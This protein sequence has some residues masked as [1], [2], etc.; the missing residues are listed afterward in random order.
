MSFTPS[1][2]VKSVLDGRHARSGLAVVL[3]SGEY[4][5]RKRFRIWRR[6]E[7]PARYGATTSSSTVDPPAA[8]LEV[9]KGVEL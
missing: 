9:V 7:L 8:K 5:G 6:S 3:R 1:Q 2:I 4:R